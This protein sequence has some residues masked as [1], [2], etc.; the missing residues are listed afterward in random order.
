MKYFNLSN[1]MGNLQIV[2]NKHKWMI[3]RVISS[4]LLFIVRVKNQV[5]KIK[6]VSMSYKLAML[7]YLGD[8]DLAD[9]IYTEHR[10]KVKKKMKNVNFSFLWF[11]SIII[12]GILGDAY[13]DLEE[14]D[15]DDMFI[16]DKMH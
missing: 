4:G 10:Q 3:S 7:L 13:V 14:F 16:G 2:Q 5:V 8:I 9:L 11:L 6:P 15:S 12:A 1:S